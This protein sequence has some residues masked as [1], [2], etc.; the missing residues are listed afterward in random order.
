M[1]VTGFDGL[2]VHAE[3]HKEW[4][5]DADDMLANRDLALCPDDWP[6][7]AA[8]FRYRIQRHEDRHDRALQQ[9]IETIE[10]RV[11]T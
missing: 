6:A 10:N 3:D 4:L 11:G 8:F 9:H 5:R 1:R 2:A 7:L